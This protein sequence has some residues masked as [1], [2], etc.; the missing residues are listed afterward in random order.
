MNKLK[1]NIGILISYI[2][3]ISFLLAVYYPL[4]VDARAQ[5]KIAKV[6]SYKINTK[7]QVEATE[8]GG[9]WG[10][11]ANVSKLSQ[12]LDFNGKLNLVY[13]SGDEVSFLRLSKSYQIETSA[14]VKKPLPLVGGAICDQNGNYYVVY[15]KEAVSDTGNEEVIRIVKYDSNYKSL[16]YTSYLGTET[17]PY[18]GIK[19]GTK[20]P[21]ASGNCSVALNGNILVCSYARV[22]YSGHQSN[23]VLYIN[24]DNL[25]K[26]NTAPTYTSHSFDQRV[27]VTSDGD[28]LF[29]DHGDANPRGFN[30]TKVLKYN[31]DIWDNYKY[32]T[33]HFREGSN[34]DYGY[35]ETY[36]QLAGIGEL[37]TGYVLAGT[38]EQT[39]SL[40]VAPTNREYCG[41]SEARDLFIQ[42]F[43]KSFWNYNE[44]DRQLLQTPNRVAE[45]KRPSSSKTKLYLYGSEVDYGVKWL[46][47]YPDEYY[48][49]NPKLVMTD[50][51]GM[52][53]LWEKYKQGAEYDYEQYVATYYMIL[54]ANGSVKQDTTLIKDLRLTNNEELMY[55]DGKILWCSSDGLSNSIIVNELILGEMQSLKKM[56]SLKFSTIPKQKYNEDGVEPKI[57]IADEGRELMQGVDFEVEYYDNFYSGKAKAVITGK[58][59]YTGSKS[60]Y[61]NIAPSDI[62]ITELSSKVK[63]SFFI[64]TRSVI[65][66]FYDGISIEYALDDK[67]TNKK[68][69]M[70][71]QSDYKVTNLT[72]KKTYYVRVRP[73]IIVEGKKVYGSYTAIKK[74]KIK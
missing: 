70:V 62:I 27:L 7:N 40:D 19:W 47:N 58:G 69:K 54:D 9:L 25:Q 44:N 11:S 4:Q 3:I 32:T 37:S 50:K 18:T 41:S 43:K 33:F 71:E 67:M 20:L 74:I 48:A 61:F 68:T 12:F 8:F 35:N 64:D 30:I 1:R 42:I 63:R 56:H 10:Y 46:T 73:F 13:D 52:I 36:A 17:C 72:S 53:L 55:I 45:N 31:T 29:A 66:D 23:H 15:G 59:R 39:L 65:S 21:F 28:Y 6:V 26:V 38:S 5:D 49:V 24:I 14:S 34:R 2:L 51:D 16:G 57:S 60:I 22:M